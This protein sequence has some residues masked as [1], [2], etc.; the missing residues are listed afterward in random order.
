MVKRI[1]QSNQAS[2][3]KGVH[4][5]SKPYSYANEAWNNF[6]QIGLPLI[7][8]SKG[9]P[10]FIERLRHNLVNIGNLKDSNNHCIRKNLEGRQLNLMH[11]EDPYFIVTIVA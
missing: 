11:Q 4:E 8:D 9:M 2:S 1:P 10:P 3:S 5:K 6:K 7:E